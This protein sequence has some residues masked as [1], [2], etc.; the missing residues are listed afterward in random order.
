MKNYIYNKRVPRRPNIKFGGILKNTSSEARG[1]W[2]SPAN[3]LQGSIFFDSKS[4]FQDLNMRF[5]GILKNRSAVARGMLQSSTDRL[6]Q[7]KFFR[8]RISILVSRCVIWWHSEKLVRGGQRHVRV[9]DLPTIVSE[10]KKISVQKQAFQGP[11]MRFSEFLENRS[12]VARGTRE[13]PTD[14]P[15]R[16]LHQLKNVVQREPLLWPIIMDTWSD[17]ESILLYL[18]ILRPSSSM[19]TSPSP[20]TLQPHPQQKTRTLNFWPSPSSS[21]PHPHLLA[22]TLIF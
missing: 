1:T 14:H 17:L 7:P 16:N 19:K 21:D 12:T 13:Q 4:V 6:E 5:G 2:E 15:P 8:F 22:L 20:S 9:A 10:K 3:S 18:L 11:N